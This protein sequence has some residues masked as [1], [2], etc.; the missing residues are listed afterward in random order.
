MKTTFFT[1][2][3]VFA[4][5]AIL[6]TSCDKDEDV[7]EGTL[8]LSTRA[9][10]NGNTFNIG[11]TIQDPAGNPMFVEQFRMFVSE[12]RAVKE[13]GETVRLVDVDQI[14]FAEGWTQS[15]TLPAGR[16]KGI[17]LSLG[18]P[19]DLN[20]DQDPAQY[21]TDHP[22]SISSAEGMFWTWNSG[23]IFVKYEGKVALDGDENSILDPY[24]FHVGGDSFYRSLTLNRSF[25]I[26]EPR[27]DLRLNFNTEQFLTGPGDTIDLAEDNLTHTMDNMPL[28]NRFMTLFADGISLN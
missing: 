4:L 20:T 13:N 11:D 23:Y 1:F 15:Y 5:A 25:E 18:V 3:T 22:L 9:L 7:T 6:L 16:Y 24:A 2:F 26:G 10:F 19:A 17:S 27:T 14:N 28:A 12:I 21:P 8:R